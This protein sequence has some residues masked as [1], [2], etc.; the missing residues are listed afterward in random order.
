MWREDVIRAR[1]WRNA[2]PAYLLQQALAMTGSY[3][4]GLGITSFDTTRT[5]VYG[6]PADFLVRTTWPGHE[7]D[8]L[9]EILA[10]TP[11][12][13]AVTLETR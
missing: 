6:M 9:E 11:N 4:R 13:L 7:P 5:Q 2:P 8:L 10:S 1:A 3:M 12:P